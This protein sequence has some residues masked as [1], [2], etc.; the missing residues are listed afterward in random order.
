MLNSRLMDRTV[1]TLKYT[2]SYLP[3]ASP[4]CAAFSFPYWYLS[5]TNLS[6]RGNREGPKPNICHQKRAMGTVHLSEALVGS[7][8]P[9]P[10]CRQAVLRQQL[11]LGQLWGGSAQ[12][13]LFLYNWQSAEIS[14]GSWWA[15]YIKG[16]YAAATRLGEM[17]TVVGNYLCEIQT[18]STVS[19][20]SVRSI[21]SSF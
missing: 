19:V 12:I 1:E 5:G 21:F 15:V 6:Y 20:R 7:S 3:G 13:L 9:H 14:V 18:G 16:C 17:L 11:L 10:A 2:H 8:P 4:L